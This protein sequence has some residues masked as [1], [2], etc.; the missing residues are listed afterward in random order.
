ME[1]LIRNMFGKCTQKEFVLLACEFWSKRRKSVA[2]EGVLDYDW[3]GDVVQINLGLIRIENLQCLDFGNN[4]KCKELAKIGMNNNPEKLPT[5]AEIDARLVG[6]PEDEVVIAKEIR[7]WLA[8]RLGSTDAARLWLITPNGQFETTPL[9]AI[10]SGE[11]KL[12]LAYLEV[13]EWS[14]V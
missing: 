2:V 10:L 12:I 4:N 11:S 6:L 13:S 8:D 14:Y 3:H 7:K 5:E 9:D 1:T